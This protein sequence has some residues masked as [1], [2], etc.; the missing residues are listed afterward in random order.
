MSKNK[1]SNKNIIIVGNSNNDYLN[2]LGK[3]EDFNIKTVRSLEDYSKLVEKQETI[4]L[5]VFTG[6]ADVNP[7]Y[8][9]QNIG[10]YTHINKERDIF[11]VSIWERLPYNVLKI[12]ICRGSQF[13]T[14]MS[15]GSLIQHV[16]GHG[17]D[18]VI[19]TKEDI[20]LTITS[21]HHQ[22]M[23]PYDLNK[24]KFDLIAWST[25]FKS[26]TY[27]NGRNE[28]IE[29]PT[30]FLEPEIVYYKNTNALAIQGHP[31][32]SSCNK[33]ASNYCLDL[34]RNLLNK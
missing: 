30:E 25:Y 34:I 15:G 17:G 5:V 16:N 11:E 28:E 18:H 13:A 1:K 9:G 20:T 27:L 12:G 3:L 22:M 21:T 6:G 26:D 19:S 2:W 8:Y 29:I 10:K 24:D 33:E 32:F 4:D 14:A 7:D 23:Y 31:E